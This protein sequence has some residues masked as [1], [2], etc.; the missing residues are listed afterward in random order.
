MAELSALRAITFRIS[1]TP[2]AQLPSQ[3]PA[4]AASL[5]NCRSLLAFSG[6]S[7]SKSA[8]EASVAIHKFRTLLATL[9]QDRTVRGRWAAIILIKSAIEVGGW[10]TLSRS[11]PWVRGLLGILTK[12]DPPSAKKLCLVTLTRIFILTREY[13]TLVREITT[14][15]LPTYIQSCLQLATSNSS[16][17]CLLPVLESFSQLLP[18]HPTIF[19]SYLKQIQPLLGQTLA[20][21]PSNRLEN[22]RSRSYHSNVSSEVSASARRLYVQFPCC[23]PKGGSSAEWESRLKTAIASTHR[24]ADQVFRAVIEDWRPTSGVL[25]AVNGHT[26]E[27]QVQDLEPDAMG[28]PPWSGIY[29]GG[30]RVVGLLQLIKEYLSGPTASVVNV[31][32]SALTDL[33]TR[34]F[35][36][37]IPSSAAKQ[38][39]QGVKLN[40]QVSKEERECLWAILPNIHVAIMEVLFALLI[41]AE[42]SNGA[43]NATLLDQLTEVYKVEK[44]DLQVRAA[45]YLAVAEVLRRTGP[46]LPKNS[47]DSLANIIR[48]C[49]E[50]VFPQG[51]NTV[52]S[53]ALV[54]NK[55]NGT[56]QQS[57][58]TDADAFLSGSTTFEDPLAN[59]TGVKSAAY[60]LLPIILGN[61]RA[62]HLS[63][64]LRTR[65]DR[66]A[67]LAQHKEAMLA[68]VLNPPPSKRFGKAAASIMP[69]LARSSPAENGVESLL[70]PRMPVVRT[71]DRGRTLGEEEDEDEIENEQEEFDED[72]EEED[73]HFIGE[74]LDNLLGTSAPTELATE[75]STMLEAPPSDTA[76]P[77]ETMAAVP[78]NVET[79]LDQA[80][81][82]V[83]NS[84]RLPSEDISPSP[85]KKPKLEIEQIAPL[86]AVEATASIPAAHTIEPS[87]HANAS[88]IL[89]AGSKESQPGAEP[90][91]AEA[92]VAVDSDDDDDFGELALGPDTDSESDA[93]SDVQ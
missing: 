12:P 31:N 33:L 10:E 18:R 73:D 57:T 15:S 67:I 84:K 17:V 45:C 6:S 88:S 2:T 85:S 3:V 27:D 39:F 87:K 59:F 92:S 49:C 89:I 80:L 50:D 69:L 32:I 77:P 44:G 56:K 47:I 28:L 13:P 63:D 21:T 37:T 7:A 36:L 9:L 62:H 91:T 65:M 54:Q 60:E 78:S 58:S 19:R 29:A 34:F 24:T 35:S 61:M 90:Q 16:A 42:G 81:S 72:D 55:A 74:E 53:N 43:L 26:V 23:T 83:S 52:L 25:A 4:I 70:R 86:A 93:G 66:T 68:S 30:E 71:L 40:N 1:S 82:Q 48:G 51:Q 14:P 5:S 38:D 75:D 41:R 22:E 79:H 46:A 20:P 8:S 11:L 76:H 64:S